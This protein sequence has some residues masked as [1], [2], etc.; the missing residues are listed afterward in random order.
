M[1]T[2]SSLHFP[3]T[4]LLNTSSHT[5]TMQSTAT[6]STSSSTSNCKY[7]TEDKTESLPLSFQVKNQYPQCSRLMDEYLS[8]KE[9]PTNEIT[10]PMNLFSHEQAYDI[11][12]K[13]R[14][15]ISKASN[16]PSSSFPSKPSSFTYHRQPV[17]AMKRDILHH[18]PIVSCLSKNTAVIIDGW[19][20]EHS[21]HGLAP[22]WYIR[23]YW[24]KETTSENSYYFK[25]SMYQGLERRVMNVSPHTSST[26][27]D[28]HEVED[29]EDMSP[30]EYTSEYDARIYQ[31]LYK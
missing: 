23:N 3:T 20:T 28:F 31:T 13:V 27:A 11:V 16:S 12:S 25:S 19:T 26:G 2:A 17:D 14:Q 10:Y 18:G 15:C 8:K 5:S 6:N 21:S 9:T 7:E 22:Y 29:D 24:G 1:A 30:D 4:I